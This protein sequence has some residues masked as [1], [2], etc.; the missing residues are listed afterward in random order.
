MAVR[1]QERI[2]ADWAGVVGPR[3]MAAA[4]RVLEE[5]VRHGRD[6]LP[7]VRWAGDPPPALPRVGPSS[8]SMT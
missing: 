5:A 6:E 2:E 8:P 4:R 3:Q 7:A 1:A